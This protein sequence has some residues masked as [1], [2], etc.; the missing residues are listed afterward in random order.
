MGASSTATGA[1]PTPQFERLTSP[2][3]FY[4][5]VTY[6]VSVPAGAQVVTNAANV[7][8][9]DLVAFAPVGSAPAGLGEPLKAAKA[10][11]L[12]RKST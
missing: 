6:Y 2:A 10:P 4:L 7:Q 11:P 12:T 8:Q 1:M 3:R 5:L 9:G